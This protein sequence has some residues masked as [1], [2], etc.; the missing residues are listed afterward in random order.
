MDR[1]N[2]RMVGAWTG[3]D[4]RTKSACNLAMPPYHRDGSRWMERLDALANRPAIMDYTA[5]GSGVPK[6]KVAI[7]QALT[8]AFDS[9]FCEKFAGTGA[10]NSQLLVHPTDAGH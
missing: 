1:R 6:H 5:P 7:G 3:D 8:P 10:G 4:G 9:H 2:V